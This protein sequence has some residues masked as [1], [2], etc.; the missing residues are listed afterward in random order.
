MQKKSECKCIVVAI[1]A[2]LA[3]RFSMASAE[4]G[5]GGNQHVNICLAKNLYMHIFYPLFP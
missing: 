1:E 5:S 4:D 3:F 2:L